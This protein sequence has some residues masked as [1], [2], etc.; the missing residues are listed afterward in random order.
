MFSTIQDNIKAT[1]FSEMKIPRKMIQKCSNKNVHPMK[2]LRTIISNLGESNYVYKENN[3]SE[4]IQLALRIIAQGPTIVATIYRMKNKQEIIRPKKEN[5]FTEN[6]LFMFRG[7]P[8]SVE[9]KE[10]IERFMILYADHG[11]NTSTFSAR[12]TASTLSDMYS[13]V[14]SA[15]G[16]QGGKLYGGASERVMGMLLDVD[17]S[18]EVETYVQDMLCREKRIIG[19][20][21]G[22]YKKEDPRSKYL[23]KISKSLCLLNNK[24]ELYYKARAIQY[25]IH[26]ERKIF[27]NVSFYA[28]LVLNTLGVPK[29]FFTSFFTSSRTAGW[30]SHIL[31]Q[32]ADSVLL[33]PTSKYI[34]AYGTKFI[35]LNNR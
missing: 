28:A 12:I 2:I 7:K 32:Y 33:R 29:E 15:I 3:E 13:G 35:P 17:N 9:E 30:T 1:L 31:E 16:T 22:V 18:E 24:K 6:F 8:A 26:K 14:T 11:L 10:A 21:H 19:F 27:P 20:G 23:R 25:V 34:G 4:N 5:G